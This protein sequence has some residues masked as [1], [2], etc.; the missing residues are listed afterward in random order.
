MQI[1]ITGAI[2]ILGASLV[3]HL[4]KRHD[5]FATSRNKG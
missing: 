2:G 4:S 3:K 5:I 1:G